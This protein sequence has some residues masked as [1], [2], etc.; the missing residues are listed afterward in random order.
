MRD[1]LETR[2]L[3]LRQLSSDDLEVVAEMLG[4]AAVMKYWPRCYSQKEAAGWI[5]RQQERY[6]R[7]GIGCWL[8]VDKELGEPVGQAGLLRLPVVGVDEVAIGYIIRRGFWRKGYAT[9]AARGSVN[10]GFGH[11]GR[12]RLITL[13]RPENEPSLGV[14][15]KLGMKLEKTVQHAGFAHQVLVARQDVVD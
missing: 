13:I 2:R 1:V 10:Y 8:A 12:D 4:D 5:V 6:L 7:D 15:R 3:A 11:L 14:A 9:D